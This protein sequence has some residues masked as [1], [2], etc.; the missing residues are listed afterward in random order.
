MGRM[1][2]DE[3]DIK[4]TAKSNTSLSYLYLRLSRKRD[5]QL[6]TYIDDKRDLFNFF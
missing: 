3:F 2:S 6:H 1:Y 4:D 5:G